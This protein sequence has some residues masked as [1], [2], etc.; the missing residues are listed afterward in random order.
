MDED[1]AHASDIEEQIDD[2]D[3]DLDYESASGILEIIFVFLL[4]LTFWHVFAQLN[5]TQLVVLRLP[6]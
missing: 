1:A 4:K 5:S 3:A 2:C 6:W